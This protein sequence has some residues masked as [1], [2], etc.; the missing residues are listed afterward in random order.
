MKNKRSPYADPN[1]VEIKD[2]VKSVITDWAEEHRHDQTTFGV[3]DISLGLLWRDDDDPIWD[4][5]TEGTKG[6]PEV[7]NE[8]E[9]RRLLMEVAEEYHSLLD[10]VIEDI[11]YD[12]GYEGSEVLPH[13]IEGLNQYIG[14]EAFPNSTFLWNDEGYP[15]EHHVVMDGRTVW[16]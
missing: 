12:Y 16:G 10:C 3:R 6:Y 5:D 15:E 1:L 7:F 11:I 13:A 9:F 14:Y 8:V 4:T 2:I